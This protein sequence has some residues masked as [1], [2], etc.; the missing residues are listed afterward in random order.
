M[1]F[2]FSFS[3]GPVTVHPGEKSKKKHEYK[4][5]DKNIRMEILITGVPDVV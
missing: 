3:G 5:R 2:L 4:T 1:C